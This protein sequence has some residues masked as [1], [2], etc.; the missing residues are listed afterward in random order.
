MST[1]GLRA[2][3]Q[4]YPEGRL[5]ALLHPVTG[6]L[7]DH[8]PAI[9][10]TIFYSGRY[11]DFWPTLF[12]L[13]RLKADVAL[14]FHGNEPQIT[15]L[16]SLAGI[17]FLFKLP[18]TSR[19]RFLLSNAEPRQDWAR[20][21]HG[22]RQRLAVARLAGADSKDTHMWLPVSAQAREH[23]AHRLQAHSLGSHAR[24][25]GLQIGASKPHRVWPEQ[26]FIALGR[27]LAVSQ[28]EL[29]LL[30]TG[31]HR[32]TEA[33][34]RV[35][36]AIGPAAIDVSGQFDLAR[37]P[38]LIQRLNLLITGD[39]GPMHIAFA[40]GTP[41]VCLF[42]GSDPSAAGPLNDLDRHR[43]IAAPWDAAARTLDVP[44]G[45]ISVADVLAEAQALLSSVA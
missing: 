13:R 29:R 2:L 45:R 44:M 26:N 16:L 43:V 21:G 38:A 17:P 37:L 27:A 28:P 34:R 41:T 36:G 14:V 12:R 35:A 22:L 33:A 40:V 11:T 19:Y 7:L 31:S 30:I 23:V 9:D 20:L 24:L 18:N 42:G 15:P 10:E 25:V 6:R 4:R 1:S 32:E 5:V 3:R 39:T 8:H